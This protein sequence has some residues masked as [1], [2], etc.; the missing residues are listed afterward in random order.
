[1]SYTEANYENAV[2]QLIEQL[3]YT[4]VYGP[5][6][7]RDYTDPLYLQVLEGALIAGNP[8][9]FSLKEINERINELL[10]Q[11]IKSDG[12]INLFA[13]VKVSY[14]PLRKVVRPVLLKSY[15]DTLLKSD[16][17]VWHLKDDAW[18]GD[19]CLE[20]DSLQ[21]DHFRLLVKCD[22]GALRY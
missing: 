16:V 7:E 2:I 11:S 19:V 20:L 21:G 13:D 12:V 6:V 5:D 14:T 1:M 9:H 18:S 3:G 8:K 17:M 10:K 22:K 4:H 15:Q